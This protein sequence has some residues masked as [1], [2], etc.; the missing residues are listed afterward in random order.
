MNKKFHILRILGLEKFYSFASLPQNLDMGSQT[1][2]F[3]DLEIVNSSDVEEAAKKFV[4]KCILEGSNIPCDEDFDERDFDL[5][6]W[7]SAAKF[8][9]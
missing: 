8:E 1:S 4:L 6:K 7:F 3:C 5:P 2:E 9:R